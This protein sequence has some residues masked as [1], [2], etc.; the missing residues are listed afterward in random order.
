MHTKHFLKRVLVLGGT[1]AMGRYA[2]PELVRLGF[3]VDVV[4]LDKPGVESENISYIIANGKNDEWLT[5]FL[6]DN[7]YDA[8][9]DF[10]SYNVSEFK[11][12]LDLLLDSTGQYLF[13][14]SCRVYANKEVPVRENSPRLLD[15]STDKEYLSYKEHEYSLYKAI[16]EDLLINSGRKNWTIILPATTYSTGRSQLVTLEANNFVYRAMLGKKVILPE[17]AMDCPATL[18]WGGDVGIMIARLVLNP[19]A[20]GEKF[21]VASAEHH[22]WREIAEYYQELI[23]L[24]YE[25]V[26]TETYLRVISTE[27]NYLF[28]K[29]QLI[30]AR[31]F[32]R[33]TDNSKVLEATGMKQEDLMPLKEGL[34]YELSRITIDDLR[35]DS[36]SIHRNKAMDEYFANK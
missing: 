19:K 17:E 20:Y 36:Y 15:V 9:L 22:T 35:A 32:N 30:Y 1:G 14:S 16:E 10:L 21:I 8:I 12:R 33:I 24:E 27:K 5:D 29:Y 18:S 13:L 26:D 2:V 23:P 28:T 11:R 25:L 31:M 6:R 34:R 7:S 3:R 4:A